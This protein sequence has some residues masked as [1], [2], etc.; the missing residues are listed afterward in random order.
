M[1]QK[2]MASTVPRLCS[3][4]A[5]PRHTDVHRHA[6]RHV[7]RHVYGHVYRH[8][9]RRDLQLGRWLDLAVPLT[10]YSCGPIYLRPHIVMALYNYGPVH[11]HDLQLARRLDL[12]VPLAARRHRHDSEVHRRAIVHL[13]D[14]HS[15]GLHSYGLHSYGPTQLWPYTVMALYSHGPI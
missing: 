3:V 15:Y 12:A 7:Y 4:S 10:E 5:C 1:A 8:A 9:H 2:V 6:Y 14:L 13:T 11:R